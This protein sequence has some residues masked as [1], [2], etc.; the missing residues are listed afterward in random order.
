MPSNYPTIDSLR[1]RTGDKWTQYPPD[2]IPAWVADMDFEVAEPVRAALIQA[3]QNSDLGYPR[4]MKDSGLLELFAQRAR[5]R[6]GWTVQP[7]RIDFFND[8]V[9]GLYLGLLTLCEPGD[10]VVIQTPIYPPFMKSVADT[11]RRPVLCPLRQG[12]H[13]FEIDFTALR[14][15]I[16]RGTRVLMLCNPHNPSGRAYT[17][18]ELETLAHIALEHDLYILS[19]EIHADLMLDDRRHIP[20]ASL[21]PD[22]AARTLTLMSA[23]KAFNIAGLG[24]AFGV[25]GSEAL[26][27]R[28][29][30][31]PHH[32]RGG[33]SALGM[34]AVRLAW[35]EGDA[36]L[37]AV[38]AQLRA[39]RELLKSHI[40]EHWPRMRFFA[41]EATY[42]AWL[43]C[44]EL[45]LPASPYRFFLEHA[46]V[47]LSEGVAFGEAGRGFVRLNFATS[48]A[49]LQEV[50][51]RMSTALTKI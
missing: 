23:S 15:K 39:N 6:Y 42:L 37:A 10:G 34:T 27:R 45:S 30:C 29:E 49:I 13:G 33:R 22:V 24:L 3:I 26:Q 11:E 12:D 7:D 14:A 41:P 19:D 21:G 8:V 51:T 50:L 20:I 35:T 5:A 25:Y 44:R 9:Q 38:I 4:Q 40:A 1:L 43:D 2:V 28:F 36:W 31:I 18:T 46:R 48:P 16:D 47:A 32:V 17:R